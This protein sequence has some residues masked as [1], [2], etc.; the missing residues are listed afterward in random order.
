MLHNKC[1]DKS[2]IIDLY[3]LT[4]NS[5]HVTEE[6]TSR[7]HDISDILPTQLRPMGNMMIPA[8]HNT[9]RYL[10]Q[11]Y[12]VHGFE[13]CDWTECWDIKHVCGFVY[14]VPILDHTVEVVIRNFTILHVSVTSDNI[15]VPPFLMNMTKGKSTKHVENGGMRVYTS[16]QKLLIFDDRSGK[17]MEKYVIK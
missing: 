13:D 16:A 14:R 11:V 5:T 6:V 8:P 12:P 17:L 10:K 2:R 9:Y 3:F 4:V 7:I 1:V 15:S